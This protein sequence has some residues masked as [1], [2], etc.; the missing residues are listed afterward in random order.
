M[1]ISVRSIVLSCLLVIGS[2]SAS[3]QDDYPRKNY[4]WSEKPVTAPE[5]N[6]DELKQPAVILLDSRY[7]DYVTNKEGYDLYVTKHK[8]VRVNDDAGIDRF[9][10]V[11]IPMEEGDELV[12]IK[13]RSTNKSGKVIELDKSNIKDLSN[14]EEYGS[15]KIFAVEGVEKESVLE[16][17]YKIK[18]GADIY[19]VETFQNDLEVKE[20][21][22]II[23]MP[24]ALVFEAKSYNGFPQMKEE[25]KDEKIELRTSTK[26][27]P[28][29]EE[30]EYSTSDANRMK[31]V[32]ALAF[33]KDVSE[34]RLMT[35]NTAA[36][37][38]Y[39]VFYP[40][41]QKLKLS[42]LMKTLA[43]DKLQPEDQIRAVEKYIKSNISYNKEY[44]GDLSDPEKILTS[45]FGNEVG[46]ARLY[47]AIFAELK[48]PVNLVLAGN[49][50]QSKF[51]AD[52][53]DYSNLDEVLIYFPDYQKYITPSRVEFRY[54]PVP[55]YLA[56]NNGLFIK[57]PLSG[58]VRELPMWPMSENK[59]ILD[60]EITFPDDMDAAIVNLK[61]QWYGYR[62][63]QMRGYYEY[64]DA[65]GKSEI[66]KS[67][68]TSGID[69]AKVIKREVKDMKMEDSAGDQP[70]TINS[71]YKAESLLE[72]A[73]KSYLLNVGKIIGRQ[74][75][76]YQESK[77]VN[78]IEM[79]NPMQYKHHIYFKIPKGYKVKGLEDVN[80]DKAY[81]E[82]GKRLCQFVSSYTLKDGVVDINVHEFYKSTHFP[83]ERYEDFRKVINAASDF[84]KLVLVLEKE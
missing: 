54:G 68:T 23:T 83:K 24:Q 17:V 46:L 19:G 64:S 47:A 8:I 75:E 42:K 71:N 40:K 56:S 79:E 36:T 45:K 16:Y 33:N 76:L 81:E 41:D 22:F 73:G 7:L 30:E 14:Y 77:R 70:V 72:N 6:K 50:Y 21:N 9:N 35:W 55:N 12:E 53:V 62:A 65:D 49:R 51:D 4:S 66:L 38:Y 39:Q 27:I 59:A 5:L 13:A 43:V 11:Y 48:I 61:H 44:G 57:G 15:F 10:K 2:S 52:F 28:A 78:D 37:R 34:T 82:D 31:V 3:A 60:A 1:T 74:S 80:I 32:Y 18:K 63:L 20:A 58:E 67:F 26:N 29:M 84:N 69:D 25:K